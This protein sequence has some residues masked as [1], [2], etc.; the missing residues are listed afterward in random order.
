MDPPNT[1]FTVFDRMFSLGVRSIGTDTGSL[2]SRG[3][4]TPGSGSGPRR[5]FLY[6]TL[7]SEALM[8]RPR[9]SRDVS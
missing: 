6:C 5:H 2:G 7:K 4:V 9:R 1:R 8:H 3:I